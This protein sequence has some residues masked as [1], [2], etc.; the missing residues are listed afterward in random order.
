MSRKAYGRLALAP[1]S[2]IILLE[3]RRSA[4]PLGGGRPAKH[5]LGREALAAPSECGYYL[6]AFLSAFFLVS[7][8][9]AFSVLGSAELDSSLLAVEEFLPL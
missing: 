4:P 3:K 8:F 2:E 1:H 6:S 5:T 7:F 9:S